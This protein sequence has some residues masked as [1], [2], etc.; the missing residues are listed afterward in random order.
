MKIVYFAGGNRIDTLRAINNIK[1]I[2]I[3]K[4]CTT[5]IEPNLDK[6]EKFAIEQNIKF[7]IFGKKNIEQQFIKTDEEILISVGYRFIIPNSIFETFK[8]AINIHPSLLP[9]YKGAYSGFAIIENG[10][11]ETGITAHF[12]DSGVD[13][14]DIIEQIKIP[15]SIHDTINSVSKN[16]SIIEPNF[17]VGVLKNIISGNFTIKKQNS[18]DN[19]VYNKKR[20]PEDSK[21]DINKSLKELYNKIRSCDQENYPAYFELDGKKV[22][23]RLDF[24]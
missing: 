18:N 4:I 9:K 11:T 17:V 21:I 8:Y 23:I 19:V 1:E 13:T 14:G 7:E 10:E 5:N 22:K 24:E 6:Y 3:S 16:I 15:I 12:I 2:T 20:V